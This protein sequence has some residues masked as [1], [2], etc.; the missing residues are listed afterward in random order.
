MWLFVSTT[1]PDAF[2]V[3]ACHFF[4]YGIRA[5]ADSSQVVSVVFEKKS[6]DAVFD[7]D[8]LTPDALKMLVQVKT[9]TSSQ[10][11]KIFSKRRTKD[12]YHEKPELIKAT[13]KKKI[14]QLK[15]QHHYL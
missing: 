12:F 9:R 1:T 7:G 10:A 6:P 13:K 4:Q 14:R 8:T 11:V 15:K 5:G 3:A 2:T